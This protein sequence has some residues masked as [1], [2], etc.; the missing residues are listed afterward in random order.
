MGGALN[1]V[2][3]TCFSDLAWATVTGRQIGYNWCALC[4][5]IQCPWQWYFSFE[6][7]FS[8]SFCQQSF[9]YLFLYSFV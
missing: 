3:L 9:L 8:F 7:H 5:V 6:I 1:R 2:D 4:G